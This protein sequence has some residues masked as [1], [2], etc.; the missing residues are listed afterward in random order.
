MSNKMQ[1]KHSKAYVVH[2]DPVQHAASYDLAVFYGRKK[3]AETKR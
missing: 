3:V 1:L 2:G